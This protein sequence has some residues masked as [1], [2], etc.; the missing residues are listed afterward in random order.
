MRVPF[1][2]LERQFKQ[3]ENLE[4][5]K[6]LADT[7]IDDIRDF[8]KT[9][10]FTLG[11][12]VEAFEKKFAAFIGVKHAIGVGSGT[13]ALILSLRALGI[14]AGDEVIT[15]A[16]TFIATAGAIAGVG[17]TPVFVDV[18]DEFTIDENLIEGAITEK[19][20]AIM[21]IFFTGNCPNMDAILD[22]AH[23]HKLHVV[24]DSCCGIDARIK[25]KKAGSMGITGTFSFHPLKNLNVWSDGGMVTTNSDDVAHKLKLLRNHGLANRDEVECFGYNSRLD[26]LQAV[27]ALRMIDDVTEVT[28]QRIANAK[29][30]DEAFK[31]LSDFIEIPYRNPD[32]RN[33]FHLYMLRV[34]KRDE[35]LEYCHQHEIE[36]KV[37]Y[38]I[39]LP[40]QNCCKHLGYKKG[41]FPKAERDRDSIITLPCHQCLT[42]AEINHMIETIRSFYINEHSALCGLSSTAS[43][44]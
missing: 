21:P 7:I 20:K 42:E 24:E 11:S 34:K 32:Y 8:L 3:S 19:T 1:S 35:L 40:Y 9:S 22:I 18:N 37:H 25:D 27:V 14:G 33:V 17:A 28:N 30:L 26:A 29:R 6:E 12:K 16:E 38:P 15:C 31:D 39:E 10:E 5:K 44:H 36:A 23:K 4:E 41:D 43:D 2:Y 13:D